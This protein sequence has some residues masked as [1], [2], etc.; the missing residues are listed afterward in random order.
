V[1]HRLPA[2]VDTRDSRGGVMRFSTYVYAGMHERF[3]EDVRLPD[4]GQEV[5]V[6]LPDGTRTVE[7]AKEA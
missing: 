2:I 4:A 5:T 3:A 1:L 6:T 7:L